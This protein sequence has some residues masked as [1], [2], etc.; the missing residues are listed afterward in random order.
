MPN[1]QKLI[2][3]KV[4]NT[5]LLLEHSTPTS[6]MQGR[7]NLMTFKE[8]ENYIDNLTKAERARYQRVEGS[9]RICAGSVPTAHGIN[10][11]WVR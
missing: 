11:C 4:Y 7:M 5:S 10:T 6:L 8:C 3:D 2:C 1:C 9:N